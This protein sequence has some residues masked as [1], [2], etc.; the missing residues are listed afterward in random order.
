[1]GV[2]GSVARGLSAAGSLP[3]IRDDGT[4]DGIVTVQ[5]LEQTGLDPEDGPMPTAGD[6]AVFPTSPHQDDG[7]TDGGRLMARPEAVGGLPPLGEPGQVMGPDGSPALCQCMPVDGLSLGG[8]GG[9]VT[10][11]RMWWLARS[12]VVVRQSRCLG[13]FRG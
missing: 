5:A 13:C 4:Y 1:M 11:V 8:P 7:V 3:V 12:V 6:L 10:V 9:G 2:F